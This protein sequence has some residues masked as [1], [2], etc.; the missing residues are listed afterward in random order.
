MRTRPTRNMHLLCGT[1]VF[2]GA[3]IDS[4]ADQSVVGINQTKACT[5]QT[6]RTIKTVVEPLPFKFGDGQRRGV[7]IFYTRI[8]LPY[9][10]HIHIPDHIVHAE[11]PILI[12]I[13]ILREEKLSLI[14]RD[15][16]VQ[17]RG[18]DWRIPMRIKYGDIFIDWKKRN[19]CYTQAKMRHCMEII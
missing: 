5:R 1:E 2:D 9:Q 12:G 13:E 8:P 14:F 17:K 10:K 4:G 3:C 15:M 16:I 11:I 18:Q 6:G 7:G 19:V